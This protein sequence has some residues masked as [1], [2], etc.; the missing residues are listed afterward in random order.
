MRLRIAVLLFLFVSCARG[1]EGEATL[2]ATVGELVRTTLEA[3]VPAE[4]KG[5]EERSHVWA[6]LRRFYRKRL[7]HPAWFD[8]E[9]AVPAA[10]NLIDAIPA[11]AREGIEPGHYRREE[12]AAYL[13]ELKDP[14]SF[15]DPLVQRRLVAADLRF[16]YAFMTLAHHLAVGRFNPRTIRAEWYTEPREP[17]LGELMTAMIEK[18]EALGPGLEALVPPHDAY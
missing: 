9:G 18:P 5:D 14:A 16:T 3:P 15:E 7:W 1:G 2:P 4:I 13:A 8:A 6:D 17:N 12:L 11:V 10:Q